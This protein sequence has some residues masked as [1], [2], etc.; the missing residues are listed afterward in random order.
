MQVNIIWAKE[1]IYFQ[2]IIIKYNEKWMK[3]RACLDT[4]EEGDR[5]GLWGCGGV[6]FYFK[7]LL[8]KQ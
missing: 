4:A 8:Q 7:F 6:S 1:K 5:L 3:N 2:S